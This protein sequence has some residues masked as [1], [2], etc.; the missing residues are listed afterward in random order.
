MA[1]ARS[2]LTSRSPSTIEPMAYELSEYRQGISNHE[3][4]EDV[5]NIA[6]RVGNKYL[7]YQEY[8][9]A[10][11]RYSETT[12]RRRF[13]SWVNLLSL[14]GLARTKDRCEME[15]V[16]P[17]DILNDAKRI[18]A[19][20]NT[21]SVTSTQ[22]K[23]LGTYAF[24]T[25]VE[26]FGSW[27]NLIKQAGLGETG[28]IHKYSDIE[29][30]TEIE[31]LWSLL[32]RQPTTTDLRSGISRISL[33]ALSRRFGGWRKALAAFLEYINESDASDAKDQDDPP[34]V[35]S[36]IP[37]SE[38][39]LDGTKYSRKRTSRNINL[40]IRFMVLRHDAFK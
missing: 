22:Y 1:M 38:P 29:L 36:P 2:I 14:C 33:E 11:G 16:R 12:F 30:F 31:R 32:G 17:E 25:V 5:K 39:R 18:A 34:E 19:E 15:R 10:G 37:D 21:S 27:A 26:K 24:P 40:K 7:S 23:A 35:T 3:L 28:F 20:L 4:T 9:K 8:R 13:G 6:K